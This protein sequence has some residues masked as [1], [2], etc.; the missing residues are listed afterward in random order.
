MSWIRSRV[1]DWLLSRNIILSR[2]P[3]Q[4]V[5]TPIKL[6]QMRDRGLKVGLAVDGGAATG[7]WASEFRAIYP[8]AQV[9]CIEPRD[10]TQAELKQMRES[11]GGIHLAQ[12]LLGE[13]IGQVEFNVSGDQSSMFDGT[14]GGVTNRKVTAEITT[15]DALVK[16]LDLPFPDLI[17]LDLQGA[18]LQALAGATEC[19][20][21]AQAVMLELSFIPLQKNWPLIGDMIPY[22]KERGFVCY[23]ITGLWHRPLDGALAQ[24]DFVFLQQNHP[25]LADH[26]WSKEDA[27]T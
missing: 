8:E 10:E 20:A 27:K 9:L 23:D 2:P 17:K 12:T 25:L 4:F 1:K 3:G 26:R 21:H 18:E 11:L 14:C 7:A 13:R 15:L 16:K 19:L 5:V 22:M 24:G 6:R